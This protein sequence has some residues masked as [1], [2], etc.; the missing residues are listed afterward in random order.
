MRG[1]MAEYVGQWKGGKRLERP[2]SIAVFGPPGA[3]KSFAVKQIAN[4]LLPGE[5]KTLEFNLSQFHDP[6]ELPA[7][8]HRL[9]DLVL[10]QYLPLVF[11]DDFD[12]P[13]GSAELGWLQ[14]D[15]AVLRAFLKIDR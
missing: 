14:I 4:A 1:I 12:T 7:S 8:F 11:W 5:L 3:G 2:L 13:L 15:E 6:E 10:Q 9:R